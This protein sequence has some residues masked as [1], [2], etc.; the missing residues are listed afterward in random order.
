MPSLNTCGPQG[1]CLNSAAITSLSQA[2]VVLLHF[3]KKQ[4]PHIRVKAGKWRTLSLQ[5]TRR[6][7]ILI[8]VMQVSRTGRFPL[9]QWHN[10]YPDTYRMK[11]TFHLKLNVVLH[12]L[13]IILMIF[14]IPPSL[15]HL[16]NR[17]QRE[18]R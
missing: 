11:K 13:I 5:G 12:I 8:L 14:I 1:T 4:E 16:S 9:I 17:K 6:M 15:V 18:L 2:G 7:K 3:C 10:P